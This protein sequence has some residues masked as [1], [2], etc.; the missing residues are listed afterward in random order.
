MT[1]EQNWLDKSKINKIKIALLSI[2]I[3]VLPINLF[4]KISLD[5][6]YLNGFLVDY[7]IPKI[8]LIEIPLFVFFI[9]EI[10]SLRK[11]IIKSLKH[12]FSEEKTWLILTALI[13]IG[14]Q[15]FS[16]NVAA[17]LNQLLHI[18]EALLLFYFLK[19]DPLFHK[20]KSKI[21]ST[22][23]IT[24]IFQSFLAYLQF[25]LQ[26]SIF[27]Y[28]VLGESNLSAWANISRGILFN[29]EKILAYASTAHPNILAGIISI[30]TI[31]ILE[32]DQR[33]NWQKY[34]FVIN[35]LA[36]ISVTQSGSAALTLLMYIIFRFL[37]KNQYKEQLTILS[38]YFFL[39][40]LPYF[41][42]KISFS[43]IN[44]DSI[45]RRNYLNQAAFEIL[46]N[47]QIWGTGLNNFTVFV[48]EFSQ[49]REVVRFVQPVHNLLFLML[50]EGGLILIAL[51]ILIRDQYK[52]HNFWQKTLI[53]L[54]IASLDHYL[55][56]Q[57]AGLNLLALFYFLI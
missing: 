23:K 20:N 7:L 24:I 35:N 40:L 22:L 33:K 41:M 4:W 43:L 30:F 18:I 42:K 16:A 39:I 29:Q 28:W 37:K 15:F 31:L 14:R 19:E 57:I 50:S 44:P 48:E 5:N 46:R 34:L 25:A 27:P 3:F 11:N 51:L 21:V 2:I 9:V 56:T 54:A 53:L 13:F 49:N 1:T 6:A 32:K 17:S 52:S 10:F 38:Y 45:I 26:R 55:L 47:K 8:Y 36:I 12:F